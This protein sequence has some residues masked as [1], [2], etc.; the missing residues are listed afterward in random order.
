MKCSTLASCYV[1]LFYGLILF[2]IT[3]CTST[4]NSEDGWSSIDGSYDGEYCA[5]VEYYNP[6]TGTNSTYTL[7][8]YVENDQL[9]E[10]YWPN[11]GVLD[12]DHFDDSDISNGECSFTSDKGYEYTVRLL[13]EPCGFTD[14]S[15]LESQWEEDSDAE[16]CPKCGDH[17]YSFDDY[18]SSCEQLINEEANDYCSQ[19]GGYE[20]GVQGGV[21][22]FCESE[23]DLWLN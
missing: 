5:E 9:I 23:N 13:G 20:Y 1:A 22:S 16:V 19:C 11:G 3:S 17:K 7:N 21:C 4:S 15:E 14:Q 18:C 8:V 10:V 12:Q 2:N 6:N